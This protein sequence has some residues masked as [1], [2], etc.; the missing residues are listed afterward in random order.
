MTTK[1]RVE[2]NAN[3]QIRSLVGGTPVVVVD[4]KPGPVTA[5]DKA[6]AYYKGLIVLVGSFLVMAN[7]SAPLLESLPYNGKQWVS[8]AIAAATVVLTFLKANETW[9]ETL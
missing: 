3:S 8:G 4:E 6:K 5:L 1:R 9:I 2:I 7:E